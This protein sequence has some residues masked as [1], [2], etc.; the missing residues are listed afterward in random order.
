[1]VLQQ[2]RVHMDRHK[3]IYS[4]MVWYSRV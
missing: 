1:M 3:L 2:T 4:S